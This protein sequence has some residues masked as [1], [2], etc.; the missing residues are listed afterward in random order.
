M[1]K[2][3]PLALSKRAASGPKNCQRENPPDVVNSLAG[4]GKQR[5]K[6]ARKET[7]GNLDKIADALVYAVTFI[8]CHGD[9]NDDE[10][11]DQN[12]AAL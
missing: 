4:G 11:L 12:V 1:L 5:W 9:K 8:N 6:Q 7:V 2:T 3:T 10:L